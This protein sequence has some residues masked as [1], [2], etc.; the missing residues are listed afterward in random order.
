MQLILEA[1]ANWC[2]KNLLISNKVAIIILDE[3]GNA[4]FYNIVLVECY[5]P[6]K[7]PR[8][9]CINLTHAIYMPLYYILL[10][11]YGDTGWY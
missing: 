6:N 1:G 4:S 3:Y 5:T 7:Q 9:C 11:P 8:Y 10:F 2:Y